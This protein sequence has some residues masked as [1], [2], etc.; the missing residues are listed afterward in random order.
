MLAVSSSFESLLPSSSACTS[1]LVRSSPGRRR[2]SSNRLRK[3]STWAAFPALASSISARESGTGSSSR[4]PV[5]AV[6]EQLV[7]FPGDA[8]H[9]A[10][11]GD[12]QEEGKIGNHVHKAPRLHPIE[13]GI[14]DV[15]DARA[16]VLH[17]TGG[18]GLH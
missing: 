9:F 16:H 6:E 15:L 11:D 10:D 12:G 18:K 3:Y 4:P 17:P 14:D 13:R 2:L 8:Q 5:R 1:S 7:V